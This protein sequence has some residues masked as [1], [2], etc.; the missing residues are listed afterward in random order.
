MY[1]YTSPIDN[2]DSQ[3][4]T[5]AAAEDFPTASID[6][7]DAPFSPMPTITLD[8]GKADGSKKRKPADGPEEPALGSGKKKAKK[9]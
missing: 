6:E 8:D 3:P 1:L 4:M 2:F 9:A 5:S 7:L